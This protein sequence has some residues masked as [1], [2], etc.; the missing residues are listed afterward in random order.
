WRD[1][2]ASLDLDYRPETLPPSTRAEAGAKSES[3]WGLRRNPRESVE[4]PAAVK[5]GEQRRSVSRAIARRVL[6]TPAVRALRQARHAEPQLS[7]DQMLAKRKEQL[8]DI[9]AEVRRDY[10][11]TQGA[12]GG[13]R[14]LSGCHHL[15]QPPVYS[16]R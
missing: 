3:F 9:L 15:A 1:W 7:S 2:T 4:D 16:A 5:S 6:A 10:L 11:S 14:Q 12:S 8:R 13:L